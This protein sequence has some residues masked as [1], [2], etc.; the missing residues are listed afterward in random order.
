MTSAGN[1]LLRLH[2]ELDLADA[3]AAELDIVPFNRDFAVPPV[4]VDLLLH[5]VDIGDRGVIEILAPDEGRELAQESFPGNER[6]RR[7][8]AP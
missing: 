8:A 5:R 7:T 4:G 3:A 1:E 2:E 6:R